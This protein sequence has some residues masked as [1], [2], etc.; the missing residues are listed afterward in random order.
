MFGFLR[1]QVRKNLIQVSD[2]DRAVRVL[3]RIKA[4]KELAVEREAGKRIKFFR[5]P[6][7]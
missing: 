5:L 7:L 1:I 6:Y 2:P 3:E 4:E